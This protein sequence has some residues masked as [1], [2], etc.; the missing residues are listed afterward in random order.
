MLLWYKESKPNTPLKGRIIIRGTMKEEEIEKLIKETMRNMYKQ[1]KGAEDVVYQAEH[2]E[3]KVIELNQPHLDL[4][5]TT[6]V[7]CKSE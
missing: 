4:S 1:E 6:P 2:L 3:Q 7:I 5:K